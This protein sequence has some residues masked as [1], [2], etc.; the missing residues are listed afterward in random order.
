MIIKTDKPDEHGD[1][2][3]YFDEYPEDD[4]FLPKPTCPSCKG[5]GEVLVTDDVYRTCFECGGTGA[6]H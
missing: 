4:P 3:D 5:T 2:L 1:E 6:F